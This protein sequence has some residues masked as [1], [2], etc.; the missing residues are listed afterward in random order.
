VSIYISDLTLDSN[1][2]W[3][4]THSDAYGGP[5]VARIL[6]ADVVYTINEDGSQNHLYINIPC[7]VC[8]AVSV[9]PVGGGDQPLQV[10]SMF[11]LKATN[12]GCPCG[13]VGPNRGDSLGQCHVRLLIN[14]MD[15]VGHWVVPAPPS[16]LAASERDIS[17]DPLAF[18]TTFQVVSRP[19]DN[20]IVGGN[21]TGTVDSDHTV[22]TVSQAEYD[23]L[24]IYDP[25]YLSADGTTVQPDPP[26]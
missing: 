21:P 3:E 24:M 6:P 12:D 1:Q 19:S 9:Q 4:V 11:T 15:G 17:A 13:L 26:S 22:T 8:G 20:L 16:L 14:R 5:H 25:A 23:N 10:Q 2:T 7:P 18:P